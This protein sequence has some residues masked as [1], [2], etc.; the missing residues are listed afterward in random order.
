F[1]SVEKL[2]SGVAERTSLAYTRT[3]DPD[4]NV[5]SPEIDLIHEEMSRLRRICADNHV[6]FICE[7]IP[8][9]DLF[10]PPR[11]EQGIFRFGLPTVYQMARAFE[12]SPG[13]QY[14]AGFSEALKRRFEAVDDEYMSLVKEFWDSGQLFE[15][16]TIGNDV[17]D[18]QRAH[19]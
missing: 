6:D 5:Y 3:G 16:T 9:L 17:V 10:D 8:R 2:S 12:A 4:K 7:F 15:N 11:F 14:W 19:F 13:R 18:G 1:D